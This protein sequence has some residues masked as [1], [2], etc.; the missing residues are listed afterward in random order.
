MMVR[1]DRPRIRSRL[2]VPGTKTE[3]IE[4]ASAAGADAVI[5]DLE[6]AVADT[7]KE[8]ARAAVAAAVA[9]GRDRP[10]IFVRVNDTSS[11]LAL[12]DLEAVVRPGLFGVVIPKVTEPSEIAAL[13]LVLA[14]L[15]ARSGM[16]PGSVVMSPILETAT[17]IYRAYDLAAASPRVEYTGGIATRGGDVERAI[18]Y[19]WSPSGSE[20]MALR[21]TTLVALRA[22]GLRNPMTGI[23]TDLDDPDG[24]AGFARQGRDLGYVGMDTIH[25]AHVGTVNST[26]APDARE[27]REARGIVAAASDGSATRQDGRMV[28]KAMLRTAEALLREGPPA[29]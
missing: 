27:L 28:D 20:S 14:W 26:F 9:S 25:P 29:E 16:E 3:W 24:L 1:P 17:A 5:F 4:K 13:D 7:D 19:R 23:W 8:L 11:P 2:Y 12:D 21:A 6:D 15:E 18:G 10:L 22:A